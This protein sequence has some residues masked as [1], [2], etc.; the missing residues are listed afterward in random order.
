MIIII[1][2]TYSVSQTISICIIFKCGILVMLNY[3][4]LCILYSI[5][6]TRLHATSISA[7][8]TRLVIN[9]FLEITTG[10]RDKPIQQERQNIWYSPRHTYTPCIILKIIHYSTFHIY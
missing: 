6:F 9:W 1:I 4:Y 7:F 5:L 8:Y 2:I 10:L 3:T